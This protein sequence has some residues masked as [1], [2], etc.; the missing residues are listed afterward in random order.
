MKLAMM[1]TYRENR[2]RISADNLRQFDGQWVAFSSDG[3]RVVA[4]GDTIGHLSERLIAAHE[5]IQEVVLE[6]IEIDNEETYL[7]GAELL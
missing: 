6:R 2:E 3:C 1:K 5:D 4:S 7:G